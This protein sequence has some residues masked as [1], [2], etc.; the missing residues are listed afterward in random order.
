MPLA[1]YDDQYVHLKEIARRMLGGGRGASRPDPTELVHECFLRMNTVED[2]HLL[3]TRQFRG[4]SAT[5]MRNFLVDLARR[6]QVKHRAL[7]Y[8]S[9][10]LEGQAVFTEGHAALDLIDLDEALGE[11]SLQHPRVARVVELKYFDG[12]DAEEIAQRIGVTQRTINN[13]WLF[14]RAW[15]ARRLRR[16][17]RG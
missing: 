13:D 6:D 10:S 5:T 11:L 2:L 17:E 14:G 3:D 12:L 4:Y 1:K 15:L 8:I 7:A 16:G 9:G